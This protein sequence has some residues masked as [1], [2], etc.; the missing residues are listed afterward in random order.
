M[1]KLLAAVAVLAPVLAVLPA[2]PA[3]AS[4]VCAPI[5]IDGQPVCQ[6]LTPIEQVIADAELLL[7]PVLA[8]GTAASVMEQCV[9]GTF[10]PTPSRVNIDVV[11]SDGSGSLVC[12]GT[13][14]SI[15]FPVASPGPTTH[16]HVPEVCV[17]LTNTCVGP[18]DR[19]VAL[20]VG[21]GASLTVCQTPVTIYEDGFSWQ[22]QYTGPSDCVV[23]PLP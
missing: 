13:E 9:T 23:V 6:D 16:L 18:V 3:D 4:S 19:D 15:E 2:G 7:Q 20:P 17:T 8:V 11:T 22:R 10:D 5:T 1:K 21:P 14:I 12:R